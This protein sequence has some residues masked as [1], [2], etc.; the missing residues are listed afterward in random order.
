MNALN[1]SGPYSTTSQI[2][3]PSSFSRQPP[4]VLIVDAS[5]PSWSE[6]STTLCEALDNFLT[7]ASSLEE[8]CRLPLLSLYALS[9]QHECLLPFV[10]VRGNLAR[11]RCC[12]EE[13]RSLPREGFINAPRGEL[14]KQVTLV[15]SLP[16]HGVVRQLEARLKNTDLVSL[17]RLLVVHISTAGREDAD[18]WGHDT[19]SPE[20]A[21]N[22]EDMLTLGTEI[23]L[24]EV[25]NSVVAME[26]MLKAWLHDQAGD[27]E[28]LH[29]LLPPGLNSGNTPRHGPRAGPVYVKCDIEERLLSP[30]LL[31]LTPYLG[32]K[33]DS[34]KDFLVPANSLASQSPPPQT[35]RVIK[36]LHADGVCESVLY[37]LPLI[38]RP[39]TC[40]QLDWE[41]MENN[42]H[43]F[44][45]LCRTLRARDWFLLV[46]SEPAVGGFTGGVCS[47]YLLQPSASLT[48][49]LK[50]VA[51][52]ELLLPC[53]LPDSN[54]DPPPD[55]L[56]IIQGCL[57]QL[58]L[59]TL[60]NP[61]SLRS[62]LYQHLVTRE[63]LS[64]PS[65]PYKTQ[66]HLRRDQP[67][68]AAQQPKQQ[69]QCGQS[70]RGSSR[71][72][73]A[74][75]PFP[76][77][78]PPPKISRLALTTSGSSQATAKPLG[79]CEDHDRLMFL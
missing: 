19:P 60:F 16:G 38:V 51:N 54:Q 30:A 74:V 28:Q 27:R 9:R 70:Q 34:P 65:Y 62:N 13:L 66:Q 11:L 53:Q 8:P 22:A 3:R 42:Q 64:R 20:T 24:Q 77:A 57:D 5:P 14:L 76:S 10:Q 29:L 69:Q 48:L 79:C 17:R 4:R 45:A 47:H 25:D 39:T 21:Q 59:D 50:P 72:R 23:D 63:A 73:V 18:L 37:G 41:D 1:R 68:P 44:H 26:M 67:R 2:C 49:L 36:A 58:E 61:L 71:V 55:A 6:M 43:L 78:P 35:L 75:A 46:R 56:N 33:T 12:V 7:L 52:R 40:W 31:P 32:V 15:T